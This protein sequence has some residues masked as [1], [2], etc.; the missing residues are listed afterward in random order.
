VAGEVLEDWL[1][2]RFDILPLL[3]WGNA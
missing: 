2:S 3:E 1:S